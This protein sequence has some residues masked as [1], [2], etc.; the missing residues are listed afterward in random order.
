MPALPKAPKTER[1]ALE[2][3]PDGGT[4]RAWVVRPGVRRVPLRHVAVHS[5][6]GFECGYGGSGPA[7]LALSILADLFR[8]PRT[9]GA[10]KRPRGLAAEIWC[11]HQPFKVRWIAGLRVPAGETRELDAAELYAWARAERERL[12]RRVDAA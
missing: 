7:D 12:R 5:P 6:T 8:L 2:R 1:Y 11:L 9:A 3:D 4:L 10:W